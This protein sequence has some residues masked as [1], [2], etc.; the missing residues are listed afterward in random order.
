MGL[1]A[2]LSGRVV[3]LEVAQSSSMHDVFFSGS[4]WLIYCKDT[5]PL[6]AEGKPEGT[7]AMIASLI[8]V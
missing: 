2:D 1:V 6:D 5:E 3:A 8:I 4:P 7:S